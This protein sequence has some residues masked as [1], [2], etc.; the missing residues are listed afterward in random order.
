MPDK[1]ENELIQLHFKL[2]QIVGNIDAAINQTDWDA[3]QGFGGKKKKKSVLQV[4]VNACQAMIDVI[5]SRIKC[6]QQSMAGEH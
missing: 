3:L 5:N 2:T 4:R 1:D 6:D